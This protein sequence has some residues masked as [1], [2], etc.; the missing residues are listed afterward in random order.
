[1]L[2]FLREP[3]IYIGRLSSAHIQLRIAWSLLMAL[4]SYFFCLLNLH[5][6]LLLFFG[7]HY[8][9]IH[10]NA[11]TTWTGSLEYESHDKN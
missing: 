9:P 7:L 8:I 3:K 10:K 11:L 2:Y 6:S 4:V 5:F 1:M